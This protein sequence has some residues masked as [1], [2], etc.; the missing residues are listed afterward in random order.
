METDGAQDEGAG[1]REKALGTRHWALGTS[2]SQDMRH[3]A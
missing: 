3:E 1:V 2:E